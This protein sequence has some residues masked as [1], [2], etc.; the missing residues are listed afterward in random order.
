MPNCTVQLIEHKTG[1]VEVPVPGGGFGPG[2]P[3][4]GTASAGAGASKR[5]GHTYNHCS[6][7]V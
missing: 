7:T 6:V 5:Y 1:T 2:N 4:G 3:A